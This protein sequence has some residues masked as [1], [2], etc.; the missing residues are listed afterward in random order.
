MYRGGVA[1]RFCVRSKKTVSLFAKP[2]TSQSCCVSDIVKSFP[3]VHEDGTALTK[4]FGAG[5]SIEPSVGSKNTQT[6]SVIR[7]DQGQSGGKTKVY[8]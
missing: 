7:T 4:P 2:S 3:A 6:R 8:S 1:N 5:L